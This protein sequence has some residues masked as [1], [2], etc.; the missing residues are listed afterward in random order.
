[1]FKKLNGKGKVV[2]NKEDFQ[3][4]FYTFLDLISEEWKETKDRVIK[5]FKEENEQ[6]RKQLNKQH[7]QL[8]DST[9]AYNKHIHASNLLGLEYETRIME[10]KKRIRELKKEVKL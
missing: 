4:F 9:Q 1:M 10:L 8:V 7:S 3:G 6:L 5:N 2:L